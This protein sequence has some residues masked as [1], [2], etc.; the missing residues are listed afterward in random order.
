MQNRIVE[1]EISL[2]N[3]KSVSDLEG[4]IKDINLELKKL[5]VGSAEFNK[6]AESSKAAGTQLKNI[7]DDLTVI[8][9]AKRIDGVAKLGA[10]IAASFSVATIAASKFSDE[11][12][13]SVQKAIQTGVQLSVVLQSI[14]AIAEGLNGSNRKMISELIK[15][16]TQAGIGAKLFGNTTRIAIASTGI[17]LLVVLLGTLIANWEKVTESVKKFAES[18]PFLKNI[19]DVVERIKNEVGSLSNLFSALG[20]GIAGL[21]KSGTS[22]ANEFYTALS[23]GKIIDALNL[24]LESITNSNVQLERRIKL[25]EAQGKNETEIYRLRRIAVLEELVALSEL[26]EITGSLTKDQKNRLEDLKVELDLLKL[27]EKEFIKSEA[28][29]KSDA[30]ADAFNKA[31]AESFRKSQE[32]EQQRIDLRTKATDDLLDLYKQSKIEEVKIDSEIEEEKIKVVEQSTAEL[33]R[34]RLQLAK[35]EENELRTTNK[36]NLQSAIDYYKSL[37]SLTEEQEQVL[38]DLK[39]EKMVSFLEEI[40]PYIDATLTGIND[41]SSALIN[42]MQIQIE[43]LTT[44]I[45]GIDSRYT[46]SIENR[47]ALEAQLMDSQGAARDQI[48]N[49]IEE[50]R[51]ES[52]RLANEKKKL[53]NQR[54]KSQNKSNEISWVN[55]LASAI[56][57]TAKGVTSALGV[58]PPPLGIALAAIVGGLG[59]VQIGVVGANKPKPIPTF[60]SGGYTNGLGFTDNTGHQVAGVVHANEYVIPSSILST[61]EGKSI[62]SMLEAMRLNMPSF[63]TGGFTTDALPDV[64]PN[65]SDSSMMNAEVFKSVLESAKIYTSWTE[66][67]EVGN[68]VEMI[69][70][71]STL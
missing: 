12:N 58:F 50:E 19:L 57:N 27:R 4:V 32:I 24:Q 47:K 31:E 30:N 20:S 39:I 53:E 1:L 61:N 10:G 15:G 55:D 63:A 41:I 34:I 23:N 54:I 8:S 66:G 56:S 46:E 48:L 6:L 38:T 51:K 59:A 14:K 3:A 18:I 13:E 7:K 37:S 52:N 28:R 29:K 17:G 60:A 68:H 36:N 35:K 11:T 21:F 22:F 26:H 70:S 45:D 25:L 69:E 71:R 62:A 49:G 42:A 16:F 65:S 2:K 5:P 64:V 67:R 40:T 44:Q 33:Y 9:D 43:S